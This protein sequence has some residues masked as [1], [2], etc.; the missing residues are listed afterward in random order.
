MQSNAP[1]RRQA[2]ELRTLKREV[3]V[4]YITPRMK[5]GR[6][7]VRLGINTCKVGPLV[8]VA[9]V[10]GEGEVLRVIGAPVL[11]RND[12]LNMKGRQRDKP[13]R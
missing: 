1:Y 5:E 9:M 12:V 11:L 8:Q 2:D 13:L 10:T 7:L 6:D 3:V 4:P